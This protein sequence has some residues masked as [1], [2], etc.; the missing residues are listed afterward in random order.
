[1]TDPTAGIDGLSTEVD[2]FL[3]E[4]MPEATL[5][6][7]EAADLRSRKCIQVTVHAN[8]MEMVSIEMIEDR[9]WK[10]TAGL[11]RTSIPSN[12]ILKHHTAMPLSVT[13]DD[14]IKKL[15]E[16]YE[17]LADTK[18]ELLRLK[19]P[20]L[21]IELDKLKGGHQSIEDTATEIVEQSF[22]IVCIGLVNAKMKKNLQMAIVR[23]LNSE[24]QNAW[25][26]T[27]D[28]IL[29][30]TI[31]DGAELFLLSQKPE[32]KK[33]WGVL[34]NRRGQIAEN[35]TAFALNQV[36]QPFQGIS[37]A[38]MKTHSHLTTFLERVGIQLTY[39]NEKDP[40]TGQFW[41]NEA[42]H[43]YFSTHLETDTLVVTVVQTKT[44]ERRPWSVP[45]KDKRVKDI[46][47]HARK[48]LQQVKKDF[49]SF[50]EIFPD[51]SPSDFTQIR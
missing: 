25:A 36:L 50:K 10:E 40:D 7:A 17:S 20:D 30:K 43:D 16:E 1:M 39:S 41:V 21:E 48:C 9:H 44:L 46:L 29:S 47:S 13:T 35:E 24:P 12:D 3:V 33:L 49:V 28:E 27:V 6:P 15:Q 42:E 14:A 18:K 38:G 26:K 37:V 23:F 31:Q 22:N 32:T 2:S 45:S 8:L 19:L 51:L 5:T 11:P 4:K 34:N